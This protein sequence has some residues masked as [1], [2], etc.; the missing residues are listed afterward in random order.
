MSL[1]LQTVTATSPAEATSS[2][3]GTFSGLSRYTSGTFVA[4]LTGA[5]GGTLDVYLQV[6]DG[7]NWI[8]YAHFPQKAGGSAATIVALP[9][10]R[11]YQRVAT[12][13]TGVDT[14]ALAADVCIGGDFGDAV[15]VRAVAGSGTSA[16]ASQVVKFFATQPT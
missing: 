1:H 2:T 16:G 11:H 7:A 3:L 12:V 13:A 9:V 6:W 5:T 10:T 15:R 8:D 4:T 14:P